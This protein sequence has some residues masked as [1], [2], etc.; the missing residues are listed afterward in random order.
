MTIYLAIFWLKTAREAPAAH[1]IKTNK[2]QNWEKTCTKAKKPQ[3]AKQQGKE[4]KENQ[5]TIYLRRSSTLR[6]LERFSE[7]NLFDW[8]TASWKKHLFQF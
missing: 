6:K 1:F 3:P 4:K 8:R 7:F 2:E 5:N